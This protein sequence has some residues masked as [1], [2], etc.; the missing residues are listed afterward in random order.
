MEAVD[1]EQAEKK[2]EYWN[3]F[4]DLYEQAA[5]LITLQSSTILYS[6]TQSTKKERICEVGTGCG[7]AVRMFVSQLMKDGAF[8]FTSDLSEN[9]N[10]IFQDRFSNSDFALNGRAKLGII[11]DT[12]SVDVNKVNYHHKV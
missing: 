9:M 6:I 10:Q 11:E 4:S 2:R 3:Q 12:E 5:E 8:I 7:L 1:Q